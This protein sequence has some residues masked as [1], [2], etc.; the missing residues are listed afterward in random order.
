MIAPSCSAPDLRKGSAQAI[1]ELEDG[2]ALSLTN[3]DGHADRPEHRVPD[4]RAGARRR[5]RASRY[6]TD[7]GRVILGGWDRPRRHG[8]GYRSARAERRFLA[9]LGPR[10]GWRT[11]CG[12]RRAARA[13]GCRTGFAGARGAGLARAGARRGSPRWPDDPSRSRRGGDGADRSH[14]RHR[15]RPDGVR[16]AVCRAV[17]VRGDPVVQRATVALRR[18]RSIAGVFAR[19]DSARREHPAHQRGLIDHAHPA[20]G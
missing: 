7:A 10:D 13:G 16:C 6:R 2:A 12:R 1:Y 11:V 3:A 19:S 5:Y 20:A 9:A 14:D 8:G 15:G 17:A 4:R 18:V